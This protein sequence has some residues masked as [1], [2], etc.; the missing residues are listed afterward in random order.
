MEKSGATLQKLLLASL[1]LIGALIAIELFL[2]I[3]Q[4][5]GFR[6]R[7]EKIVLP[8]N[9]S[10]THKTQPTDKL[11][12]LVTVH[13]N[14]LGFRGP[15]P[16]NYFQSYL[17]LVA[18]GGSTTESIVI[19]EGKTWPDVLGQK[20]AHNFHKVWVNNAGLDGHSTFGHLLLLEN[21]LKSL[22]P[23]YTLFLVGANDL[24]LF[25][26]RSWDIFQPK[27]TG[28]GWVNWLAEKSELVALSKNFQRKIA[29]QQLGLTSGEVIPF[30]NVPVSE[31][32][33]PN[34]QALEEATPSASLTQAAGSFQQRLEY[35]VAF[36][37]RLGEIIQ[38]S[39]RSGIEPI[40]LTQPA[41]YG[42]AIDDVTGIDLAGIVLHTTNGEWGEGMTGRE[43]WRFLE[44]YNAVTRDI[45]QKL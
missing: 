8:T 17:T 45:G 23:K 40:L 19:S 22:K 37:S 5:F 20:L 44:E 42:N 30:E 28:A 25:E 35:L 24:A 26:G 1:A 12:P 27:K 39:R 33:Y 38:T 13:K 31:E 34:Y 7:G 21:Y 32:A 36:E 2:R 29:T 9:V 14:E 41:L 16:P 18:V 3:F 11:D 4:P 43:K 10:F 6:L 15:N